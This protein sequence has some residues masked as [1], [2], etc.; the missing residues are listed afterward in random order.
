MAGKREAVKADLTKRIIEAAL[1]EFGENGYSKTALKDIAERAGVSSGVISKYYESKENLFKVTAMQAALHGVINPENYDDL[2]AAL[3]LI[4]DSLKEIAASQ[5]ERFRFIRTLLNSHDLPEFI[6]TVHT[7]AFFQSPL[8]KSI[9]TAQ[10]KGELGA[11]DP[12]LY[13]LAFIRNAVE[14][15]FLCTEVSLPIPDNVHFLDI[16]NYKSS[17][18][19]EAEKRNQIAMQERN[20][21]INSVLK[22]FPFCLYCNLTKN[23]YHVIASMEHTA[24][25]MPDSGTY[26]RHVISCVQ[27]IP[28]EL[29]R[30]RFFELFSRNSVLAAQASGKDI[31][32]YEHLVSLTSEESHWVRSV[33]MFND[34]ENGDVIATFFAKK[35]ENEIND[36]LDLSLSAFQIADHADTIYMLDAD[37]GYYSYKSGN[38]LYA[39]LN[40][41]TDVRQRDFFSDVK[42]LASSLVYKEDIPKILA[43]LTRENIMKHLAFSDSCEIEYRTSSDSPAWRR[44]KLVKDRN[45]GNSHNV[46]IGIFNIN[47]QRTQ[48]LLENDS[49]RLALDAAINAQR[50][51]NEYI[52]HLT[53]NIITPLNDIRQN[54]KMASAQTDDP[55][56]MA[57]LL[58]KSIRT[59]T[60]L[61]ELLEKASNSAS[62]EDAG[63]PVEQMQIVR[64]LE[65]GTSIESAIQA[66]A[67]ERGV[68]YQ[69]TCGGIMNKHIC[70]NKSWVDFILLNIL[71]NSI[72]YTPK[73]G[74]VTHHFEQL[75][76]LAD[77]R[78]YYHHI[79]ADDSPAITGEFFMH[80]TG[81]FV[82]QYA[83]SNSK[84][85][86]TEPN[87]TLA[88]RLLEMLGGKIEVNT[89]QIKGS[90]IH[91][92][93]PATKSTAAEY[94][95]FSR[96]K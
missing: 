63:L 28:D 14:V 26:D 46:L 77:G 72:K 3:Y 83:S 89:R 79:I 47:E 33:L 40:D 81:Y 78:A 61:T 54:L 85:P 65:A 25:L 39:G 30:R 6:I 38:E 44:L 2:E 51:K 11:G 73:G 43:F 32:S 62:A 27:G 24:A 15:L 57:E 16:I 17:A 37:N 4:I 49:F 42:D 76:D 5:S 9:R 31:I 95:A 34:D 36:V 91:I 8:Y 48:E 19:R 52:H 23:Q 29:Q 68:N 59:V 60:Q 12:N 66:Y 92:Y 58:Q 53:G 13:M 90:T 74:H 35:I 70:I 94:K 93:I 41:S 88:L 10:E 50:T 75:K 22:A 45:W 18:D 96:K 21:L 69:L 84:L 82:Q 1:V 67:D 71:N 20:T 86:D 64:L 87:L 80:S 56:Q 55:T 7:N